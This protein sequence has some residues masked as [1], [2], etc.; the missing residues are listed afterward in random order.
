MLLI[1]TDQFKTFDEYLASLTRKARKEYHRIAKLYSGV[2]YAVWDDPTDFPVLDVRD[3]MA[4]WERQLI[5]G[6]HVEWAFPVEHVEDLFWKH[7]LMLFNASDAKENI[8]AL[9]FI[10]QRDGYWECHPP[11]YDKVKHP[12]LAKFMW[13]M[14]IRFSIEHGH[15]GVLDF[16]GGVDDWREHIRR[17]AEFPNPRYKW[18]YVPE[19]AKEDPDSEPAYF[20]QRPLCRLLL[21]NS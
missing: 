19:R 18:L 7:Q 3:F 9:H 13:F 11:M 16:G 8:L 15:L 14:L 2:Y 20:I 21:R 6:K 1:R 17:R 12:S 5:R 4:L 10:Q